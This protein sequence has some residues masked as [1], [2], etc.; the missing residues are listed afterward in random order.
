M[1][2]TDPSGNRYYEMT[3]RHLL[4]ET[5]EHLENVLQGVPR[6]SLVCSHTFVD[7]GTWRTMIIISFPQTFM[8]IRTDARY[9][10]ESALLEKYYEKAPKR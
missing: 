3:V 9:C 8:G 5:E 6:E 7:V 4:V 2:V 10:V 1:I